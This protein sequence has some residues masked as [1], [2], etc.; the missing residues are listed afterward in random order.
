M[1]KVHH[2]EKTTEL[3][4]FRRKGEGTNSRNTLVERTDSLGRDGVSKKGQGRNTEHTLQGIDAYAVLTQP[5]EH[6]SKM[7]DVLF[8]R[9]TGDEQVIDVCENERQTT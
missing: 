8:R 6:L 1:V 5:C 4:L 3:T 9:G 7:R 2:A